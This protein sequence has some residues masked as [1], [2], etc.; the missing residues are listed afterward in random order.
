M[1]FDKKLATFAAG[2]RTEYN[3]PMEVRLWN[4]QSYQLGD[5]PKVTVHVPKASALTYL[6]NPD[7]LSWA[8]PMSR[9]ISRSMGA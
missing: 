1:L 3:I 4:G 8:R 2:L 6:V 7:L 5:A 9:D